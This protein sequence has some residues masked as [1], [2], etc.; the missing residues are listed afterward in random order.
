MTIEPA[1]AEDARAVAQIHVDAWR[2]AYVGI[3][4]DD[5][6]ASLSVDDREAMWREAI[7]TGKPE[8][9]VARRDGRVIGWVSF[10]AARAKGAAADVGELWAIYLDPRHVATGAGRALWLGARQRLIERG[11]RSAVLWV[12]AGNT[13]AIRFYERAG[14]SLDPGSSQRFTLGGREIEE[15]RCAM[16]L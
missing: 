4:P 5:Y 10:D 12:L 16:A 2:A 11:F 9:L 15:L 6:L 3:V 8:M 7:A 1:T 14:F 13:R